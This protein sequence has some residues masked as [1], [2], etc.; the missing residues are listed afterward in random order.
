MKHQIQSRLLRRWDREPFTAWITLG[1]FSF[2]SREQAE[3]KIISFEAGEIKTDMRK[4]KTEYRII[5]K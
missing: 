4:N 5:T 2:D 1:A 3:E